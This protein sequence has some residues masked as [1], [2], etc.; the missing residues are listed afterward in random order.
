MKS[1]PAIETALC[2]YV[3]LLQLIG[4]TEGTVELQELT[5]LSTKLPQSGEI[6]TVKIFTSLDNC[7][8]IVISHEYELITFILNKKIFNKKNWH[9][10]LLTTVMYMISI[11]DLLNYQSQNW[12]ISE[13]W[14]IFQNKRFGLIFS[15]VLMN[16]QIDKDTL[17]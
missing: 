10:I 4:K 8:L 3:P 15:L 5:L 11:R 12:K 16:F 6:N 7:Y 9:N 2:H 1:S 14:I 17:I 13:L